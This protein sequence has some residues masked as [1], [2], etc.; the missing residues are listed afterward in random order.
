MASLYI[1]DHDTYQ[2]ATRVAARLGTSKTAAV[3]RALLEIEQN[4]ERAERHPDAPDWLKQFWRD[5]PLPAPTGQVAD[6][7]FFDELSGDA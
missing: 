5:H 2:L 3:R 4:M 7:A 1:K 6:K